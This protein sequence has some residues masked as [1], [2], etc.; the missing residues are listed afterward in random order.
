MDAVVAGQ[1]AL[2]LLTTRTKGVEDEERGLLMGKRRKRIGLTHTYITNSARM[3]AVTSNCG[4]HTH[5]IFN[6]VCTSF[7][8]RKQSSTSFHVPP[9]VPA[10]LRLR[11]RVQEVRTRRLENIMQYNRVT[12]TQSRSKVQTNKQKTIGMKCAKR[13]ERRYAHQGPGNSPVQ[14]FFRL[15]S[16]CASPRFE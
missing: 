15:V 8:I 10:P 2:S 13:S 6:I 9:P 5:H 7:R 14:V 1:A 16:T 12:N 11:L 4:G 3:T